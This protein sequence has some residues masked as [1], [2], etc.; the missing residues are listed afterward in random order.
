MAKSVLNKKITDTTPYTIQAGKYAIF[1][2]S[3]ISGSG[4]GQRKATLSI[5]GVQVAALFDTGSGGQEALFQAKPL[6]AKAGDIISV[7]SGGEIG[8]SGF[9]FDA[10]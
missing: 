5:G 8:I 7:T 4:A 9:E 3:F 2:A 6:T 10:V 1:A